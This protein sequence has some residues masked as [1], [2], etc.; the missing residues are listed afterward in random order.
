M[1]AIASPI[2]M[3][4]AILMVVLVQAASP[5]AARLG[6]FIEAATAPAHL[7]APSQLYFCAPVGI[8]IAHPDR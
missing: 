6:L 5:A 1:R 7:A 3:P 8:H 2:S 4:I